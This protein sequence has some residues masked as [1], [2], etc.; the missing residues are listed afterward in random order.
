MS[1]LTGQWN[2]RRVDKSRIGEGFEIME[3]YYD[4]QGFP[5]SCCDFNLTSVDSANFTK[6]I[7]W[8]QSAQG[9]P[10][11]RLDKKGNFIKELSK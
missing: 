1:E 6:I 3:V 8:L 10:V 7:S 5:N 11:L 9:K 2:L 4:E